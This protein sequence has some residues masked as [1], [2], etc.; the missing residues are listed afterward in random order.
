MIAYSSDGITWTGVPGSTTIFSATGNGVAW[1][2]GKGC[3]FIDSNSLTSL[4]QLEVV[5]DNYNNSGYNNM[6]ITIKN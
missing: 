6:T 3:V 2:G 4:D 5:A 1:N